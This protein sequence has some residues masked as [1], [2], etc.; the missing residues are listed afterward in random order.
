MTTPTPGPG[1]AGDATSVANAILAEQ[2][3][4]GGLSQRASGVGMMGS[5]LSDGSIVYVGNLGKPPTVYGPFSSKLPYSTNYAQAKLAPRDWSDSQLK[6]FVNTGI[7]NKMPGFDTGMG[8]PEVMD[9]WDSLVQRTYQLNQGLVE[10]QKKWTP[11]DV[12]ATYSNKKGSFGTQRQGDWIFD[13]ATGERIKYVG[14]TSKTTTSKNIDLSSPEEAQALVTQVLRE[15]IGRAPTAKEL[16]QFK[17]T[18]SG[19]EKANP[20]VTKT[21]QQL[22]PNLATGDVDV[23]SQSSVTSGGV[24]DAARAALVQNPIEDTKEYGKYQSGTTYF[25]ALLA[26][27]GGS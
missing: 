24:S 23:T 10:G 11:A 7:L 20:E 26:M 14:P 6:E 21:T 8:L 22:S 25:N 17:S 12:M 4:T 1:I 2:G 3:L 15:A 18:I 16:A 5:Q 19:F 9:A 13:V 27:V